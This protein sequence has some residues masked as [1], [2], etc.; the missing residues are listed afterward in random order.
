MVGY[1]LTCGRNLSLKIGHPAAFLSFYIPTITVWAFIWV[2][3]LDGMNVEV[4]S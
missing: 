1:R 2:W 4:R 3:G